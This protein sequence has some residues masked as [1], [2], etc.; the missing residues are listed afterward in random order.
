MKDQTTVLLARNSQL[1]DLRKLFTESQQHDGRMAL[2]EGTLG[3]GK[4]ALARAFAASLPEPD[5]VVLDA[6]CYADDGDL[7]DSVARQLLGGLPRSD[8][9]PAGSPCTSCGADGAP[10]DG[11]SGAV[12][13]GALEPVRRTVCELAGSRP[14]VLILEDVHHADAES[15]RRLLH[16]VRQVRRHRIFTVLTRCPELGAARSGHQAGWELPQQLEC[17]S[18]RVDPFDEDE[19]AALLAHTLDTASRRLA[20]EYLAASGGVPRFLSAMFEDRR[21][22][23]DER[24]GAYAQALLSCLHRL[25][26]A[27][28]G[29]ARAVA[30]LGGTV[31]GE[32][33]ARLTGADTLAVARGQQALQSA[34]VLDGGRLR[35]PV[36]A[37]VVLA[38]LTQGERE[39]LYCAAAR[40]R[41]EQGAGATTVARYLVRAGRAEQWQLPILIEASEQA[42]GDDLGELVEPIL[43]LACACCPDEQGRTVLRA[44]LAL[45]DWRTNAPLSA[46]H[47]PELADMAGSGKL[48]LRETIASIRQLLWHGMLPEARTAL[49]VLRESAG[50]RACEDASAMCDVERWLLF[51]YPQL[52]DLAAHPELCTGHKGPTTPNMDPWLRATG[53][54]SELLVREPA[55][56]TEQ[57]ARVLGDLAESND[58]VWAEEAAKLALLALVSANRLAEAAEWCDRLLASSTARGATSRRAILLGVRAEIAVRQGDLGSARQH[59]Q[60]ALERLPLGVGAGIALGAV[61]LANTLAGDTREA[62]AL[63]ARSVPDSMFQCH[64]GLHYLYARGRYHLA[65][66]HPRAALADFMSCGEIMGTW[67]VDNPTLVPWRVGA[68]EAWLRLRN[69][70]RARSLLYDQLAKLRGRGRVRAMSLRLLAAAST[71]GRRRQL[72]TEAAEVAELSGDHLEQARALGDLSQAY[73]AEGERQRARMLLRRALYLAK[74][75]GARPL[76]Q[77]LLSATGDAE[78]AES[79]PVSNARLTTL[80]SSELRVATLA[81][82]GYTN[83]EIAGRLFVT[84]STVEQHLTKVY[85]KLDVRSRQELPVGLWRTPASEPGRERV[86][87]R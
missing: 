65:T 40:L 78:V 9:P 3:A 31:S 20:A 45:A 51:A 35:H 77:E 73:E 66:H 74:A 10:A 60:E 63:L 53:V 82:M 70:D 18:L 67:T 56:A 48:P 41:H 44:R 84:D 21:T 33:V 87:T 8:G 57:A 16:F 29:I 2:V 54:L 36:A 22:G 61:I 46:R 27:E 5:A 43:Q 62:A 64:H 30:A 25:G 55:G 34:G 19:V 80:T 37:Q 76:T 47:L 6:A 86:G 26:E 52:S 12:P 15:L 13:L 79:R 50:E 75:S 17:A 72:L 1:A 4:T 71:P 59:G 68:A 83:R 11:A 39:E 32:D 28:L 58:S 14:V 49:A 24:I 23:T 69:P 81:A 7:L 85:R 38:E 42:H